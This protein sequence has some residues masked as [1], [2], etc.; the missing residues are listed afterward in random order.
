MRQTALAT[1][2]LFIAPAPL[3]AQ[4]SCVECHSSLDGNLKAPTAEFS[5]DIHSKAFSCADCHGGD[6]NA[7]DP[8]TSMSRARGFKG[9]IARKTVPALCARCHSDAALMHKYKPQQRVDQLAQYLTSVHGKRLAAGDESVA[10][11]VD[12][13]SVHDIR[14][15]KH[16]LSPAHP[17]R[18][19]ETCGRCHADPKHMAGYKI[20]TTQLPEYQASV[21]WEALS[22]RRDLSAP[23]C[24]SCHGNHGATPPQVASVAGVCGSCHAL[25]EDL[26]QKS[27]HQPVFEAMG[28][29]GCVA[30]H[31]NHEVKRPSDAML[32]ATGTCSQC[33]DQASEGG[34]VAAGM[35]GQLRK[36][37]AAIDGSDQILARA[38]RSGM[39]VSD[40]ILRLQDAREALI[41]ARVAVH[42]FRE[43]AVAQ[44]VK[45]GLA[46][47]AETYRAGEASPSERDFR[48]L[49]L[50]AS[51]V[52]IL[53]T[54]A[55]LWLLLRHIERKPPLPE[56]QGR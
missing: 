38:R 3:A 47:G 5:N 13:H 14:E 39:E 1:C 9:R 18:L 8:E 28:V 50:A 41:K 53:I 49:G 55:G 46:I 10:T 42:A 45:E 36:L 15:V 2:I 23:S 20:P 25:Q 12:C 11:C 51:L 6:R 21:H 16:P 19:P 26:Y 48:R 40:S 17:V 32:T 44:L 33:H 43:E 34:K 35:H 4:D 31:G 29:A 30:C 52:A 54:I 22:K 27:P 56:A 37:E 24:A 7:G